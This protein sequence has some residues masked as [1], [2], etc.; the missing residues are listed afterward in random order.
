MSNRLTKA[1]RQAIID[2]YYSGIQH[3]LYYVYLTNNGTEQVRK[4]KVPLVQDGSKTTEETTEPENYDSV[5]NKQLL[6][7]MLNILEKNTYNKDTTDPIQYEQT[8][9][10]NL[11]YNERI[12]ETIEPV[13]ECASF[14]CAPSAFGDDTPIFSKP[15]RRGR[16]L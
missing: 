5:S 8:T 13:D 15:I 16:I 2:D 14:R 7:R 11:E 3:P 10:D 9:N 12:K 4:R 6:E 1:E